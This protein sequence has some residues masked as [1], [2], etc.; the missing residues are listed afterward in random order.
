MK[1]I[2]LAILIAFIFHENVYANENMLYGIELEEKDYTSISSFEK[3]YGSHDI[4]TF[5]IEDET[6]IPYMD[7]L[8]CS[9]SGK[10]PLLSFSENCNIEKCAESLCRLHIEFIAEICPLTDTVDLEKNEYISLFQT[11]AAALKKYAPKCQTLYSFSLNDI[12]KGI[13]YFPS[14]YYADITGFIVYS[15]ENKN[16][17]FPVLQTEKAYAYFKDK[18]DIIISRF[19]VSHFSTGNPTYESEFAAKFIEDYYSYISKN[20]DKI[21]AII[22]SN[23]YIYVNLPY[24]K[25]TN[26]YRITSLK[27]IGKAYKAV[28]EK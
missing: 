20:M 13:E 3:N 28:V 6:K 22:Y 18:T 27:E 15:K 5:S 25:Y 23:K 1:K 10:T 19:A 21:S 17:L 26:D 2:I 8:E 7:I 11:S 4:Y 24:L 9:L 14:D 16:I 12:E